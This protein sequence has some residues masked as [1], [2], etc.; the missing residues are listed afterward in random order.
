MDKKLAQAIIDLN[1]IHFGESYK[2]KGD[3]KS[4]LFDPRNL[5]SSPQILRHVGKRMSKIATTKCSGNTIIGLAT[6]GLSWG[7]AAS[8]YSG[9]PFLYIRKKL[10]T[11]M[12][13]KL[14]EGIIPKNAK[15]ILVDDLL[16]AGESKTEAIEIIKNHNLVVTDIIVVIDRQLQ[17]KISGPDLETK[18]NIKLH[19]LITMEELVDYLLN[20]DK[21]SKIQLKKLIRDYQAFERWYMPKFAKL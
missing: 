13:R 1:V 9:L 21:I 18:H 10:E 20:K 4:C 16:F 19:S 15:L 8:I 3:S 6:S 14:I 2:N 11:H 12:S 7:A 5:S 17:R